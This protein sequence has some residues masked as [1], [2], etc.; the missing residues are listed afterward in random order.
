MDSI[1][2]KLYP[3]LLVAG[4]FSVLFFM[5]KVSVPWPQREPA[6]PG[7]KVQE[8]SALINATNSS[9]SVIASQSIF[10]LLD[11]AERTGGVAGAQLIRVQL[12]PLA[13]RI[14]ADARNYRS[15]LGAID[16][17]TP[18]GRKCRKALLRVNEGKRWF[19]YTFANDVA[20][21]SSVW[22]VV[23]SFRTRWKR[24]IKAQG[25]MCK[26]NF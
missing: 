1:G 21:S 10:A 7:T 8:L 25:T 13:A 12:P 15:R 6:V 17:K 26:F 9:D 11:T 24:W 14:E 2:T 5:G 23:R 3:L 22:P 20:R 19:L 16:V 4:I 18:Y